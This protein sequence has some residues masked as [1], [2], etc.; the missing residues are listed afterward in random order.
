M[1]D[2]QAGEPDMG[3]RTLT[4]LGEPLRNNYF[5]VCVSPPPTVTGVDYIVE[6]PLLLSRCGFFCLWV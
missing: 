1:R 2:P 4:P 5:P 6:V 3:L